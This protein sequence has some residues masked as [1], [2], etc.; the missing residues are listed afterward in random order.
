MIHFKV[1]IDTYGYILFHAL[2]YWYL[3]QLLDQE[4]IHVK[5]YVTVAII[6]IIIKNMY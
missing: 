2:Y 5:I 4:I 1:I 6:I 3:C